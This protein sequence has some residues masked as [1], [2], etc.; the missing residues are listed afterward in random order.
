MYDCFMEKKLIT[1]L[2][3][4][5]GEKKKQGK[6]IFFPFYDNNRKWSIME[7]QIDHLLF[8]GKMTLWF[9]LGK[10]VSIY[11]AVLA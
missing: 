6:G 11:S 10:T 9:D 4:L 2:L 7:S 3:I 8:L 5:Q 1:A